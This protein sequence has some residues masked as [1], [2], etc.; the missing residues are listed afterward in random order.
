MK[1]NA[2]GLKKI[3]IFAV[4][5][6]IL[7]IIVFA[8]FVHQRRTKVEFYEPA[9]DVPEDFYDDE[10]GVY[11]T[12]TI[13]VA[14][15][16]YISSFEGY[17][18]IN[19]EHDGSKEIYLT[20][21]DGPSIYTN[22]ILDILAKYDIKATF[23]VLAKDDTISKDAYVRI[24][25][26]GH[27]LALHSYSHKYASV[28]K[29]KES[30]IEDVTSLQEYLYDITGVWCRIYRF[31]GGS[32]NTV[33]R[34]DMSELIKYLKSE[35]ITYYDWNISSADASGK[36]LSAETI[37]N[38]CLK[39]INK[40]DE[41]VILLHDTGARKTTVDALDSIIKSIMDRGDSVFLPITDET[42]PVQHRTE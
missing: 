11:D 19:D 20:F 17:N 1:G 18:G 40:Y 14:D 9:L 33:S 27:T 21:D 2:S 6:I 35:G 36:G 25:E 28:Y 30:F 23:F 34:T 13:I 16:G 5:V 42:V 8:V 31:P 10:V 26:E 22:T 12:E 39:D 38:N 15:E 29:T 7:I 3:I 37:K 41:C 32:S 24:V 4:A